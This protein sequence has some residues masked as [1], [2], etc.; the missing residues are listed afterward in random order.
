MHEKDCPFQLSE[1]N[2]NVPKNRD[3]PGLAK[4]AWH[5]GQI[6]LHVAGRH[7]KVTNQNNLFPTG[8]PY[9]HRI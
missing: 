7:Q 1:Q 6:L 9:N 8:K 4:C 3:W 5:V 2:Q